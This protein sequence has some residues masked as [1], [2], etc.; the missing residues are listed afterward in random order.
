MNGVRKGC[1]VVEEGMVGEP[2]I[3]GPPSTCSLVVFTRKTVGN[4]GHRQPGAHLHRAMANKRSCRRSLETG[5]S[6][7]LCKRDGI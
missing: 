6:H 2:M 4:W 7:E 3:P 1:S 5:R